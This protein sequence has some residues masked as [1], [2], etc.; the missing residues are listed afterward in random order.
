MEHTVFDAAPHFSTDTVYNGM[1][2]PKNTVLILDL[3]T[4][5]HNDE[6]PD[7]YGLA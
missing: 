6:Y 5:H 3:Y 4:I 1:Y 7:P 2:I